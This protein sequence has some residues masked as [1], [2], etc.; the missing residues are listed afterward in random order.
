M[1]WQQKVFTK[2]LGLQYKIVYKQ[3]SQN[4]VADALSR[5]SVAESALA[6]STC[7]LQWMDAVVT[8][9]ARD[10]GATELITKLSL[11]ADVVPHFT[12]SGGLLR[13]KGGVWLGRDK[14]LHTLVISAMHSSA[15]GGH[16]GMPATY[17][18]LKQYFSW[19]GMKSVAKEF[20]RSC[21]VC[22]Q[23][24]PDRS[25]YPGLLQPLPVPSSAW[26]TKGFLVLVKLT[27]SWWWSTNIPSLHILYHYVTHT[28]PSRWPKHIWI[29]YTSF[30]GCHH[31]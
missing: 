6:I 9:Y 13:Y 11:K 29:M 27:V 30:M 31:P 5:R 4:R 24:K 14:D 12:L 3:G 2:L 18:H 22:Q 15:L 1:P 26:E 25:H 17:N 10:P 19:P 23:A 28:P 7:T 20:V 8:S 16:S 21:S